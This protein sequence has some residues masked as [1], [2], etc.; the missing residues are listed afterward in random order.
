LDTLGSS[1]IGD[2]DGVI[3]GRVGFAA[4]RF[5]IYAKGGAAFL[6]ARASVID[7]CTLA[8]CGPATVA[9]FGS[10][11]NSSWAAGGGIEYAWTNNVSIKAEYLFLGVRRDFLVSGPNSVGTISNWNEHLRGVST[12]KLGLNYKFDLGGPVTARY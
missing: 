7:T 2:W 10:S 5:L 1:R 11:S 12:A 8:P 9:A 3:A 6:R 4:D